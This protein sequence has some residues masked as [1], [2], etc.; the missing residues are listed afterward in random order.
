[1]PGARILEQEL[2]DEFAVSRAP[3]REAIRILEREGKRNERHREPP[4]QRKIGRARAV[5]PFQSSASA[6]ARQR[7]SFGALAGSAAPP[8]TS[9]PAPVGFAAAARRHS[10]LP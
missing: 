3:I 6:C 7:V 10:R 1:V 4:A 5:A 2:A 9:Q 8:S